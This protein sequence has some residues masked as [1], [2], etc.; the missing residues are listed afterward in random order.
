MVSNRSR[1]G[2]VEVAEAEAEAGFGSTEEVPAAVEKRNAGHRVE[3][4]AHRMRH[5]RLAVIARPGQVAVRH[6]IR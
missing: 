5:K 4:T 1:G 2:T 3:K 6:V